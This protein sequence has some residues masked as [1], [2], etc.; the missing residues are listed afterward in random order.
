M[1]SSLH[2]SVAFAVVVS[3]VSATA[4]IKSQAEPWAPEARPSKMGSYVFNYNAL[5][6]S[7]ELATTP[8]SDTY[9]P[10]QDGSIAYRW[11][12]GD[13][14]W[15]YH[16]YT[17]AE[18]LKLSPQQIADLS[19][20][21][22]FDI[23]RGLT[24]G[25]DAYPTV[26]YTRTYAGPG[27]Q[28]WE[29]I[30]HGWSPAS[31]NHAQPI[32]VKVKSPINGIELDFGSSDVKALLSFYYGKQAYRQRVVN[33]SGSRCG[34]NGG[35]GKDM[36]P[37][38]L[39]VII[40]NQLGIMKEGFIGDMARGNEVWNH[41][42]YKFET[43]ELATRDHAKSGAA[44][45]ATH[46]VKVRTTIWYAIETQPFWNTISTDHKK[47]TYTYWLELDK[48]NNIVGG[49]Y[50]TMLSGGGKAP[51]F[52]WKVQPMTFEGSWEALNDI[53]RSQ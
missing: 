35:C 48:N 13:K 37:G 26:R 3:A 12:S 36:N 43:D 17:Y 49:R 7:G 24:D 14:P 1:S 28:S 44:R 20:A 51:D 27:S 30:C 32:P 53:Y 39:H 47:R 6:K 10:H 4:L 2:R 9:W 22:K 38:A 29:G 21:E 16:R 40:A 11:Q 25:P 31:L 42:I 41:P 34:D 23:Y 52:V 15:E 50:G 18:L 5:P 46:E 33:Q 19:P 45:T 8:W